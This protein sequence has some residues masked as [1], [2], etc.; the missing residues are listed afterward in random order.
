MG[1]HFRKDLA[2][3]SFSG[4]PPFNEGILTRVI[5]A[6]R[7]DSHLMAQLSIAK[8]FTL[9]VF[10]AARNP[11]R[12]A[13]SGQDSGADFSPI[14]VP[15]GKGRGYSDARGGK[16]RAPSSPSKPGRS[17]KDRVV[18][19]WNRVLT[20]DRFRVER[21][22]IGLHP[23]DALV[24]TNMRLKYPGVGGAGST[25]PLRRRAWISSSRALP[26]ADWGEYVFRM[27]GVPERGGIQ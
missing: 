4:T 6:S 11:D 9:P 26:L 3:S 5:A 25:A 18:S 16:R 17:P 20:T 8:T 23:P 27:M 1:I 10:R 12:K 22:M 15:R 13:S 14:S 24:T 2:G 7:E 21:L 19:M